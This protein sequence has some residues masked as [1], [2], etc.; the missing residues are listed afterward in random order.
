[1]KREVGI[2]KKFFKILADYPM[3]TKKK[4]FE[5]FKMLIEEGEPYPGI[6]FKQLRATDGVW[7]S[8]KINDDLRA[9]CLVK[10]EQLLA[11]TQYVFHDIGSKNERTQVSAKE[12]K[13]QDAYKIGLNDIFSGILENLEERL[14]KPEAVKILG[15]EKVEEILKHFEEPAITDMQTIK[16]YA[17]ELLK[18]S[19]KKPTKEEVEVIVSATDE[20][21]LI[22]ALSAVSADG[23]FDM[24]SNHD[25]VYIFKDLVELQKMLD[26]KLT[27]WMLFL[28][29]DQVDIVTSEY[30]GPV[31]LR[32]VVGSGK[33]TVAL[34]RAK[35]II[36]NKFTIEAE[37]VLFI[38]YNDSLKKGIGELLDILIPEKEKRDRIEVAT[39]NS[40][41]EKFIENYGINRA[42]S[43]NTRAQ[44]DEC[45]KLAMKDCA[46]A[47]QKKV[48]ILDEISY[49][50]K[51]HGLV[52]KKSY[53]SM[54]RRGAGDRLSPADREAIFDI[55]EK[56]EKILKEKNISDF[57]DS[58]LDA[59]KLFEAGKKPEKYCAIIVDE[60]Q[61]FKWIEMK[62]I[63]H[64]GNTLK[65]GNGF[66]ML[67]GDFQQKIYKGYYTF[68]SVGI[69]ITGRSKVL[70]KNYRNTKQIFSLAREM[71]KNV[72]EGSS[73]LE[74]VQQL[75]AELDRKPDIPKASGALPQ[76]RSFDDKKGE[77]QWLSAKISELINNGRYLPG[78]IAIFYTSS[79]YVNEIKTELTNA[80]IKF[81]S[82][83]RDE[84]VKIFGGD[85]VK[86]MS[87]YSA[88]GLEFKVVFIAG[89]RQGNMPFFLAEKED[90]EQ[91]KI[92]QQLLLYVGITRAIKEL[93]MTYCSNEGNGIS[94]TCS[95]F[96][97]DIGPEYLSYFKCKSREPNEKNVSAL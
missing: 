21:S 43:E 13:S 22:D 6:D 93:Y 96:L 38:V 76:L 73:K 54:E 26:G 33:T 94:Q 59:V 45:F 56:Y 51:G 67:V 95:E 85:E 17:A 47:L 3:E 88:K 52:E 68:D 44:V 7:H 55:Y 90:G 70:Y 15:T 81:T 32:G 41:A 11:E 63:N 84:A 46:P 18:L 49:F 66:M 72:I 34:H 69:K 24:Y 83:L 29:G 87:L 30:K 58:I 57:L 78:E 14:K 12:L 27:D 65:Y 42:Y 86:I 92:R 2:T 16:K 9:I 89:V 74:E 97:K 60:I 77:A 10:T 23:L 8:I 91:G 28:H 71:V 79:K 61:D 1:M 40:W 5:N 31:R 64:I 62:L 48:N 75:K 19:G 53:L 82:K 25:K 39:I 20:K 50:I 37:K 4:V 80:A 36:N 35:H